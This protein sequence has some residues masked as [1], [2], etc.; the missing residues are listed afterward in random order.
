[1]SVVDAWHILQPHVN[2]E[3]KAACNLLRQGFEPYLSRYLKRRSHVRKVDQVPAP[4]F[5]RYLFVR[6]DMQAQGW[7]SIQSTSA[8]AR[9]VW[10]G[11]HSAPVARHVAATLKA[12]EG[13]GGYVKF[14]EPP[15]FSLGEKVSV[16]AGIFADTLGCLTGLLI[17]IV[18]RSCSTCWGERFGSRSTPTRLR[19]LE[20]A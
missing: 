9:L 15:R 3:A 14:G 18:S 19:L 12:R 16:S 5:P 7:S 10:N 4:W 8:I 11:S 1:M 17:A 13:T 2:V 6:M 20:V